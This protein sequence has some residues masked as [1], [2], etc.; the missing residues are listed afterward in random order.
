MARKKDRLDAAVK[1]YAGLGVVGSFPGDLSNPESVPSLIENIH[2]AFGPIN[3]AVYNA[4]A[5]APYDASPTQVVATNNVNTVSMHVAYNTLLPV[6]QKRGSGCFLLTGGGFAENGAWSAPFGLQFGAAAKAYYRNFAE[7]A[8]AT[9]K[10]NGVN[11]CCM[12]VC[13]MVPSDVIK[14]VPDDEAW[15]KKLG[16][17]YLTQAELPKENWVPNVKVAKN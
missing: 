13:D 1:K 9:H 7:S 16:Q 10:D 5:I 14:G 2:A 3:V 8:L 11:V 17:A 12:Q 4:S 6:F 15:R